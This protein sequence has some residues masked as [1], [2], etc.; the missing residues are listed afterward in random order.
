MYCY[1][2]CLANQLSQY[3]LLY[4]YTILEQ[5]VLVGKLL[6]VLYRMALT[7]LSIELEIKLNFFGTTMH[8]AFNGKST[9]TAPP[10]EFPRRQRHKRSLYCDFEK[11]PLY[12]SDVRV[13]ESMFL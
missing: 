12:C 3:A 11:N 2:P 7:L 10:S 4:V 13:N 8:A 9:P 1:Y 6:M 5:E